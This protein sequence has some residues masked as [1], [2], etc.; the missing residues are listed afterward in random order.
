MKRTQLYLEDSQKK[1]LEKIAEQRNTSMGEVIREAINKYI[2]ENQIGSAID[3]LKKTQGLWKDRHDIKDSDGW[4]N[5]LRKDWN[6][7]LDF[8]EDEQ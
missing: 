1:I 4:V 7:R 5:N 6:R 8:W 2:A 3:A